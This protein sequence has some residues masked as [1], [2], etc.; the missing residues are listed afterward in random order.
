MANLSKTQSLHKEITSDLPVSHVP[1]PI[2]AE[3][4]AGAKEAYL[5]VL[6]KHG[7]ISRDRVACILDRSDPEMDRLMEQHAVFHPKQP[8]LERQKVLSILAKHRADFEKRYGITKIGIFGSVARN[9]AAHTSDV[10]VVIQMK[11]PDLFAIVHL[12]DDLEALFNVSVDVVEYHERISD[13]L[14]Q[15]LDTEACYV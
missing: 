5:M 8:I 7:A 12:K 6:L 1:E 9:E 13:F 10:D 3:A 15:R 4:L 2:E 14:K 11:Q